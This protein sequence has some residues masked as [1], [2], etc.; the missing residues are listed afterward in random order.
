MRTIDNEGEKRTVNL[1]ETF[2]VHDNPS[3]DSSMEPVV[4]SDTLLK[5]NPVQPLL[6]REKLIME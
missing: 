5:E 3:L 4:S 6:E 2:L 1:G